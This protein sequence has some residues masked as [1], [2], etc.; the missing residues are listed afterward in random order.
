MRLLFFFLAVRASTACWYQS[1][2]RAFNHI[3]TFLERHGSNGQPWNPSVGITRSALD[4]VVKDAPSAVQW[5]V[6]KVHGVDGV[7][8][9]CDSNND[10]LV[11]LDEAKKAN[12]CA[13]SCWKQIG[14]TTFLN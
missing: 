14:I 10:G 13:D 3:K 4:H 6:K 12:K 1:K 9:D 2:D 7:M 5:I 8:K 11:F